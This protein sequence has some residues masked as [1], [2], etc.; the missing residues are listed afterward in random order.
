MIS[1]RVGQLAQGTD[2]PE[3]LLRKGQLSSFEKGSVESSWLNRN[4][5]SCTGQPLPHETLT[6]SGRAARW[7]NTPARIFKVVGSGPTP[8]PGR[9]PIDQFPLGA[10]GPRYCNLKSG[11]LPQVATVHDVRTHRP[12]TVLPVG[13]YFIVSFPTRH[14]TLSSMGQTRSGV[15]RSAPGRAEGD[16]SSHRRRKNNTQPCSYIVDRTRRFNPVPGLILKQ[17][18]AKS[19]T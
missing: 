15:G 5:R 11:D 14:P 9:S 3:S 19:R 12:F 2:Q 8:T 18:V 17:A 4:T 10:F 1:L 16:R 13:L 6:R 7:T